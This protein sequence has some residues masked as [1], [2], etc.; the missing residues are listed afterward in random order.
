MTVIQNI[1][2]LV[3]QE[4]D[5]MFLISVIVT[6]DPKIASLR[7]FIPPM[8]ESTPKIA[9]DRCFSF[10]NEVCSRLHIIFQR[11]TYSFWAKG[12]ATD[13]SKIH[14]MITFQENVIQNK[15][16]QK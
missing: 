12:T 13:F 11:Q 2:V 1:N 5:L 16:G 4:I 15:M 6:E 7:R 3:A 8:I 10:G 9:S 14:N